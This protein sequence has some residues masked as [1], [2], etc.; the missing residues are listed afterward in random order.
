MSADVLVL[1]HGFT[2]APASWDAVRAALP[3]HI[4]VIAPALL[5]H[6]D[7]A[8]GAKTWEDE[9]DRVADVVRGARGHAHLVGY[10]MGGRVALGVLARHPGIATRATLIGAGPGL[11]DAGER[12]ARRR[13]DD[14][15]A[16]MIELEG[17]DAFVRAWEQE[18]IFATQ[19]S[20]PREVRDR[21]RAIRLSH[22]AAGLAASLH[23]L[24][25]GA[26]PSLWSELEHIDVPCT[27]LVGGE[28]VKLRAIAARMSERLPRARVELV[29]SA[30]HDVP[31][32]R[33]AELAQIFAREEAA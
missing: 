20:L 18:P 2:G 28:D 1:L 22:S 27:L 31:L 33:P 19:R 11:E 25:Q 10:S 26:M 24:G 29:P 7:P 17:V 13:D 3:E 9:V 15:R 8:F 23:T 5:G 6:G 4:R 21:H 30:G 14:A 16:R 32:E 12:E